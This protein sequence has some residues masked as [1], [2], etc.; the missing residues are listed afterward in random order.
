MSKRN[1]FQDCHSS[2]GMI[3]KCVIWYFPVITFLYSLEMDLFFFKV[4]GYW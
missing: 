2:C 3:L 4:A 1:A